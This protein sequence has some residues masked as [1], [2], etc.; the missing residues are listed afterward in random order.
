MELDDALMLLVGTPGLLIAGFIILVR[1][2][3]WILDG[4]PPI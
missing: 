4:D 1:L 2:I 3:N